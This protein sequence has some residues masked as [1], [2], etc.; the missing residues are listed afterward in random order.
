MPYQYWLPIGVAG[1]CRL[2]AVGRGYRSIAVED[3]LQPSAEVSCP[4]GCSANGTWVK[5]TLHSVQPCLCRFGNKEAMIRQPSGGEERRR[6]RQGW[7]GNAV[8]NRDGSDRLRLEAIGQDRECT[9][10]LW[11]L[12]Q[13]LQEDTFELIMTGNASHCVCKIV[14]SHGAKRQTLKSN[15]FGCVCIFCVLT[16]RDE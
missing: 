15:S 6:R 11:L 13:I 1:D 9:D 12:T 2:C 16:K 3:E 4:R 10:D 14:I 8:Y 7:G 5:I